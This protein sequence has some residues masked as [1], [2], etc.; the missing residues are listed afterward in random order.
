MQGEERADAE[1]RGVAYD[2]SGSHTSVD[3]NLARVNAANV[4][5]G[6]TSAQGANQAAYLSDK[7]RIGNREEKEQLLREAAR[8]RSIKSEKKDLAREGRD[9]VLSERARLRDSERDFYLGKLAAGNTA[10][11]QELSAQNSKRSSR[12][13]RANSRRTASNS[14]RSAR[15]SRANSKRSAKTSRQNSKRSNKGDGG[16]GGAGGFSRQDKLQ[17][18]D[19]LAAGVKV[20]KVDSSKERRQAV[21][22]LTNRGV[23]PRLSRKTVKKALKSLGG[24]TRSERNRQRY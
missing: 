10:R 11:G 7:Q 13:S 4:L 2:A 23:D 15:V 22:Y 19:Y 12:T 1:K 8:R 9:V 16:G 24:R 6:V 3:A 14:K 5:S 18:K 21:A 17:A 20:N